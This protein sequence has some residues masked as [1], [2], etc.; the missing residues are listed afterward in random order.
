M[1]AAQMD[2]MRENA[3]MSPKLLMK[4][5]EKL[6]KEE[7]AAQKDSYRLDKA[8]DE[9]AYFT[10]VLES[11]EEKR[12]CAEAELKDINARIAA[13]EFNP[14]L[15]PR[16]ESDF[17]TVMTHYDG[18]S[19]AIRFMNKADKVNDTA[20]KAIAAE[21]EKLKRRRVTLLKT[22]ETLEAKIF[23]TEQKIKKAEHERYLCQMKL[24]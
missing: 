2:Y 14:R 1:T 15:D 21:L 8:E 16:N 13:R 9:I 7:A 10:T 24:R 4:G 23:S 17:A 5:L 3:W 12:G 19:G 22:L 11:L 20:K 18:P 6:E